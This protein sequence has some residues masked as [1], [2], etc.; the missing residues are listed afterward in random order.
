MVELVG[1]SLCG[2][3]SSGDDTYLQMRWGST[4]MGNLGMAGDGLW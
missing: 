2:G 1:N 4:Q 3:P